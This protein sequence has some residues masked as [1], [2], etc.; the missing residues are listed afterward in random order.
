MTGRSARSVA[1]NDD[2][3]FR[4]DGLALGEY[5]IRASAPQLLLVKPLKMT[6]TAAAEVVDVTLELAVQ[7]AN[8]EL[9]VEERPENAVT[10]AAA[11]NLPLERG[12][13][14][15]LLA[16]IETKIRVLPTLKESLRVP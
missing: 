12:R 16:A 11:N 2:G 3:A 10:T 4:F 5:T 8:Q 1:S 13:C 14:R 6:L 7:L 9:N 15:S